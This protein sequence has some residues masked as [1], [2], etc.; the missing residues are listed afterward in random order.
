MSETKLSFQYCKLLREKK[1]NVEEH[2][3][4]LRIKAN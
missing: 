3:G 2:M 4:F 1:E